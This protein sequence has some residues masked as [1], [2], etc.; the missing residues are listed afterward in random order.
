MFVLPVSPNPLL[1]LLSSGRMEC[2]LEHAVVGHLN[3]LSKRLVAA[4]ASIYLDYYVMKCHIDLLA[5]FRTSNL[6]IGI[7]GSSYYEFH[8]YFPQ[9]ISNALFHHTQSGFEQ[10]TWK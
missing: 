4:Q 3:F 7:S 10:L 5:H 2:V 8:L 9:S 1:E 6:P